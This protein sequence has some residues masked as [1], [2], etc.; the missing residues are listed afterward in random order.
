[1]DEYAAFIAP[2]LDATSAGHIGDEHPDS[3]K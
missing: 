1:M 3:R 2:V